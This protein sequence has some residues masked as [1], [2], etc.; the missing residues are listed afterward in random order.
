MHNRSAI[1]RGEGTVPTVVE[2][3]QTSLRERGVVA[4]GRRIALRV[5]AR[6][7][8]LLDFLQ[9]VRF[10]RRHGVD[11]R[12]VVDGPGVESERH[13]YMPV[14]QRTFRRVIT[15]AVGDPGGFT[16]VDLGCGK[17]A[18]LVLAADL[19]FRRVIGVE[20]DRDLAAVAAANLR[21]SPTVRRS[22]AEAEVVEADCT[23]YEL[24]SGPLV[25]YMYN[26]FTGSTLQAVVDLLEESLR[27]EPRDVR[28]AYLHPLER[29]RFERSGGL[30]IA[31][32]YTDRDH[33]GLRPGDSYVIYRSTREGPS[34][35]TT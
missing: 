25:V 9:E 24:P 16:F 10:D 32:S 21:A 8:R 7:L 3:L 11:T 22:G 5:R 6:C 33:P 31:A 18:A 27:K 34:V 2:K 14:R 28:V 26:P 23:A 19:G 12:G 1:G 4:T 20:Y 15:Q 30:E 35:R 29:Q 13:G 17:G